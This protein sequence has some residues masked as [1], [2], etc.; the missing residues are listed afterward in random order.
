MMQR[1]L[2]VDPG[3]CIGCQACVAGCR[4]CDSHR[5]KSMIHL[6]YID[7]G[8]TT[9]AMP[10]VCMHCEDPTCAEV[11]P[12]DA[13]KRSGDGVV[14]SA[15]K[16]RC[17]ACGNCV[18]ACPFGVPEL[19]L[20]RQIMMKCDMC[21]DRSSVGKKPMCATVCPS[22]ALYYGT[23]EE[24]ERLRPMSMPVNQFQF[25]HQR[26][27][28]QVLMMVPRGPVVRQPL[29]DVTAAMDDTPRARAITLT[30][31]DDPFAEVEV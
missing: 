13:I 27:T 28:T 30:P 23:R 11:C 24:M 3:R 16:P 4:E 6:D 12:A 17:I 2:F 1:T 15:R 31:V 25:G 14:Q 9:A 7:A 20:D 29:V 26:I 22:Q 8:H 18:M 21:Y 10:T 5:G 19:Y